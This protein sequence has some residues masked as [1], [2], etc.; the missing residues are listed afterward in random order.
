MLSPA[1]GGY[2]LTIWW[3]CPHARSYML[4]ARGCMPG[5][6]SGH[7]PGHASGHA[8]PGLG[9]HVGAHL[10]HMAEE[11]VELLHQYWAARE[12]LEVG[13][14]LACRGGI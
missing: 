9:D 11:L 12:E 13:S 7:A 8:L 1:Y 6:A 2:A 5:H 10:H 4:V 3:I 14:E